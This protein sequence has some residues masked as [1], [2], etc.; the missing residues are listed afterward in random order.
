ME[1]LRKEFA[2]HPEIEE[3]HV[4]GAIYD[5]YSGEVKWLS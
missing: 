4:D 3:M 5:I 1:R 2:L